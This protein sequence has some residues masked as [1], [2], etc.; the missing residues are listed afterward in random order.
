[1]PYDIETDTDV[2]Q[3]IDTDGLSADH[4]YINDVD[5]TTIEDNIKKI[6]EISDRLAT[7]ESKIDAL[8]KYVQQ[9]HNNTES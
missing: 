1:M 9:L 8:T 3:L 4:I 2:I 7:L 5:M 6:S